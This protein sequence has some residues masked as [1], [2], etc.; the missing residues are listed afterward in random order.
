MSTSFSVSTITLNDGTAINPP[1]N[2]MTV[3]IG[4]NNSGKSVL[5][6]ELSPRITN[7]TTGDSRWVSE[8]RSTGTG[9]GAEFLNW[10]AE[11][12]HRSWVPDAQ[13]PRVPV[14]RGGPSADS[15]IP[16]DSAAEWWERGLFRELR[17]ML[18]TEQWA[19]GRLDVRAT[20][21]NW[22]H[23]EPAADPVQYLYEDPELQEKLSRY[24]VEAFGKPLVVD[25]TSP[26]LVLR[27]G[28]TGMDDRTPP[29]PELVRA[30][31]EL[32]QL[33]EQGDGFRALVQILL[34]TILRPT[35]V[36][37]IDEPEAFLH[38]P[39]ARLLGRML[40]Q[41]PGQT[42][43]FVATHSADFLAGVLDAQEARPL[44]LVRLD[45]SS[46]RPRARQLEPDAVAELLRTPL[47]RYSNIS[48]GLFYDRVVLCE[49]EGDCQFYAA[50]FD[51]TRDASAPYEN[52][53]FLHTSG[54][55][56]LADTARRLRT[57]GIPTAVIADFD[58]LN[59]YANV[60]KAMTALGGTV[61]D[62]SADIK[63]LN[64]YANAERTIPTVAGFRKQMGSVLAGR[65]NRQLTEKM[66]EKMSELIEGSSGWGALK[67]SGLN[68]LGGDLHA[69]AERLLKHSAAHGL[70]IVPCGELERWVRSVPPENKARWLADVFSGQEPWYQN[71]TSELREFC[72]Q[73][74]S[75]L[76]PS[77]VLDQP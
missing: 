4:P 20:S 67:K 32:P 61:R 19:A 37:L 44:A 33:I 43:V 13:P 57:F 52:T 71:P 8:V 28:S 66:I 11:R 5:L 70:F 62:M 18:V 55:D 40:A 54:K 48:S 59:D 38:P 74:R 63:T 6:R 9:N 60:R 7:P 26:T 76:D 30:Y 45:R 47:L 3:F 35:P 41:L 36:V 64:D 73:I 1:A 31:R 12:G 69:A 2:G 58:L 39:Q 15:A 50:T 34:H 42:Q 14:L 51:V 25:W 23:F 68:A 21:Q 10:V 49:A 56:R 72:Q 22:D 27:V 17:S 75:Y 16:T 46:G 24:A 65:G 29:P 53:I 77:R